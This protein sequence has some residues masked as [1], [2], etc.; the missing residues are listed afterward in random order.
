MRPVR[1][2][3]VGGTVR[4]VLVLPREHLLD[5]VTGVMVAPITST[6][7]GLGA[8]VPVGLRNGLGRDGVVSCDNLLTLHVSDL[9]R[10]IGVLL[11]DQEDQLGAAIRYAFDLR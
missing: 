10:S 8:E 3:R 1:L 7:K 2:A 4:P 9:G 6:V 11:D 5:V